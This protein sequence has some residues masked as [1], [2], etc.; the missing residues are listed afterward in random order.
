MSG[1]RTVLIVEDDRDIR[2]SLKMLLEEEK[3]TV[4]ESSNGREALDLLRAPGTQRPAVVFLDLTMPIMN[5]NC[6]LTEMREDS[7]LAEIPVVVLTAAADKVDH[8]VA[9]LMKKPLDIGDV[10]RTAERFVRPR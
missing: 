2:D 8:P 7:T 6:F 3:F 9:G 1:E 4:L 10:L 5:G